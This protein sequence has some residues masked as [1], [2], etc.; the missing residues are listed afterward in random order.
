META[1]IIEDEQLKKWI[2][3]DIKK[4]I[5]APFKLRAN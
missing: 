2:E 4:A 1:D 3:E 5:F